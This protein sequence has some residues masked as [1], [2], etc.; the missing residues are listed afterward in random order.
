MSCDSLRPSYRVE[1]YQPTSAGVYGEF[2]PGEQ[3]LDELR[4]S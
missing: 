1:D 4:G 3:S 2:Y